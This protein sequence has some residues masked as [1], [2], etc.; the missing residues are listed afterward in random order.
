MPKSYAR[1]YLKKWND[2]GFRQLLC[3]F[4]LNWARRTSSGWWDEWDD[5]ALQTRH[6]KFKPWRSEAEHATSHAT[7]R[8]Q[9]L[10]T[11]LTFTS[12]WGKNIFV[13]FKPPRPGEESRTLT[14]KAAVLATTYLAIRA[15][16]K[17]RKNIVNALPF[18]SICFGGAGV[19]R[20]RQ[21]Q[22]PVLSVSA[23]TCRKYEMSGNTNAG[24]TIRWPNVGL[25]L[26]QRLRRWATIKTSLGW[27]VVL[28]RN[29]QTTNRQHFKLFWDF[30]NNS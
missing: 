8:S 12:G 21:P 29:H 17:Q 18:L 16:I 15:H 25:M 14:W 11:I 28:A 7:S 22:Q 30:W 6:S 5:S 24:S 27:C 4:R 20:C 2:S 26:S 1:A 10:P 23:S 9:R 19:P 3:T 13:S